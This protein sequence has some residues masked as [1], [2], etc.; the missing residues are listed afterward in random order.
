MICIKMYIKYDDKWI[1]MW[2]YGAAPLMVKNIVYIIIRNDK[3][4]DI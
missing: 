1:K 2:I 3:K 4:R